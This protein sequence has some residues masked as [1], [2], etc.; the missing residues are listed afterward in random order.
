MKLGG[1]GPHGRNRQHQTP[2]EA[3]SC[4]SV[5]ALAVCREFL[6]RLR[7]ESGC[8]EG[9]DIIQRVRE[10]LELAQNRHFWRA[11]CEE[12]KAKLERLQA[13]YEEI[14]QDAKPRYEALKKARNLMRDIDRIMYEMPVTRVPGD[15]GVMVD[16]DTA[17]VKLCP[18]KTLR[19]ISAALHH[20][21]TYGNTGD[22]GLVLKPIG[23]VIRDE[24]CPAFA[25]CSE[26]DCTGCP[27]LP[28]CPTCLGEGQD[29]HGE[30]CPDCQGEG[31]VIHNKPTT[32]S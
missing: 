29:D 16:A 10:L 20:S 4:E 2:D 25:G 7:V 27:Y 24:N 26:R 30:E 13:D 21:S 28:P 15:V 17:I 23:N 22:E 14:N 19:E 6:A 18:L 3:A 11:R 12:M 5:E 8:S 9:Q 1:H 31:R 32:Q